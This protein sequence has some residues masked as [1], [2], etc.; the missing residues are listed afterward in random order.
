ML[1][2]LVAALAFAPVAS[3]TAAPTTDPVVQSALILLDE[4]LQLPDPIHA[5]RLFADV[6]TETQRPVEEVRAHLRSIVDS[7][8]EIPRSDSL[9]SELRG[10]SPDEL[11]ARQM[12]RLLQELTRSAGQVLTVDEDYLLRLAIRH[13]ASEARVPARDAYRFTQRLV[14]HGIIDTT[15][16]WEPDPKGLVLFGRT[17]HYEYRLEPLLVF[18]NTQDETQVREAVRDVQR[19]IMPRLAF[20]LPD[21]RGIRFALRDRD[22]NALVIP[23]YELHVL[24]QELSF[25]GTNLDLRP[26]LEGV[27]ELLEPDGGA[28]AFQSEFDHCSQQRDPVH[29][30]NLDPFFDE[31]AKLIYDQLDEFFE[32]PP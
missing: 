16:D 17:T 19:F 9:L 30:D 31:I 24:V 28:I 1:R 10:L 12:R 13:A 6:A 18:F 32:T 8:S 29:Q 3:A 7:L 22:R 21:S 20:N 25:T 2:T 23:D 11:S 4:R 14:E 15:S 27:I 26:C 5:R